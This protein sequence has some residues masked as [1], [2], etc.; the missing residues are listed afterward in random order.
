MTT[1]TMEAYC[2]NVKF[3]PSALRASASVTWSASSLTVSPSCA[4]FSA[5]GREAYVPPSVPSAFVTEAASTTASLT[6]SSA[7]VDRSSS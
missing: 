3:S 6:V 1:G 2:S 4:A 7:V 5:A